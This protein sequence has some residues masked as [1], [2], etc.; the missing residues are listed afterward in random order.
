[1][2]AKPEITISYLVEDLYARVS[3][4]TS[5]STGTVCDGNI[6]DGGSPI[7]CI[8]IDSII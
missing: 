1:M 2:Y 3:G 7:G 8:G 4:F 5:G 6:I